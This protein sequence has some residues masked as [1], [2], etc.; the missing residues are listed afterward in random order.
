[1]NKSFILQTSIKELIESKS[2]FRLGSKIESKI[3][4]YINTAVF[5]KAR[6]GEPHPKNIDNLIT[7]LVLESFSSVVDMAML[8]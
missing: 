7:V 5:D 3:V 4:T 6:K 1:M 8:W 2:V